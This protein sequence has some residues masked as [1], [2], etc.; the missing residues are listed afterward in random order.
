MS[1]LGYSQLFKG[2]SVAGNLTRIDFTA[3]QVTIGQPANP[4]GITSDAIDTTGAN[5]VVVVVCD[6]P[7]P[8]VAAG[9]LTDNKGNTPGVNILLAT[10]RS[11]TT[12]L[13]RVSIYYIP[14][15]SVFGTN[16]TFTWST[17]AT[18]CYPNIYVYAYSGATASP[19]L[20]TNNNATGSVVS[21]LSTNS[22]TPTTSG[23]VLITATTLVP[24]A[25]SGT[26]PTI[27]GGGFTNSNQD[28]WFPLVGSRSTYSACYSLIQSVAGASNPTHSFSSSSGQGAVAAI[29]AFK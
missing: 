24:S 19:L 4:T 1:V 26:Q 23:A 14:Q 13:P 8:A 20:A 2:A 5:L 6:Y 25:G 17:G 11:F 18:V 3:K 29:A 27:S 15:G 22:I 9:V 12:N 10:Q 21:S 7:S 28:G 16:H